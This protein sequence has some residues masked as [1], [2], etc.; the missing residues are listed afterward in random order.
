MT[1]FNQLVE[2]FTVK[3]LA[4]GNMLVEIKYKGGT[5][6][7][8]GR[9]AISREIEAELNKIVKRVRRGNKKQ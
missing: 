1:R 3:S 5:P 7:G 9:I 8:L 6:G 2:S 4:N